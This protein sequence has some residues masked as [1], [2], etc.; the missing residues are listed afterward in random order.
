MTGHYNIDNVWIEGPPPP[1]PDKSKTKKKKRP[2]VGPQTK[3]ALKMVRCR[4]CGSKENLTVDH[5]VPLIQGGKNVFRNLQCLCKPCNMA[6]SGLTHGQIAYLFACF[7]RI[8]KAR[9]E[10]GL[11]PLI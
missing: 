7:I 5:K 9:A 11:P 4:Y 8:A 3:K 10:N 2:K 1:A 6:K